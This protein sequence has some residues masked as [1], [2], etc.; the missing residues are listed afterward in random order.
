MNP[1]NKETFLWDSKS[2]K[3]YLTMKI[4]KKKRKFKLEELLHPKPLLLLP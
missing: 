4:K 1:T 2:S 3:M